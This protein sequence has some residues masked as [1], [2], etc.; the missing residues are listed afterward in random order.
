MPVRFYVLVLVRLIVISVS[1]LAS[2]Y[3]AVHFYHRYFISIAF[4][5]TSV[6]VNNQEVSIS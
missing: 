2:G 3:K 4:L 6:F 5:F 1:L